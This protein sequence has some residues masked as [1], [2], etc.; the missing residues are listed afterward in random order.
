[1]TKPVA[2]GTRVKLKSSRVDSYATHG[3]VRSTW[4]NAS[5]VIEYEVDTV[6]QTGYRKTEYLVRDQFTIAR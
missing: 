6:D 3:T 5:G 4:A 1:M 2:I